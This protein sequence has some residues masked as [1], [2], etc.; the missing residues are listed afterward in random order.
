[1]V[2]MSTSLS[3]LILTLKLEQAA[4]ERLDSLRWAHF[5]PER[6]VIPALLTLFRA[7]PGNQEPAIHEKLR[8]IC[9]AMPVLSLR[10]P[11]LR[12]LGRSVAVEVEAPELMALRKQLAITWSNWLSAQ[13]QQGYRPHITIQNKVTSE[14]ARQ[15][16]AELAAGWEPFLATGEKL[17]LWRYLGGPWALV[18]VYRFVPAWPGKTGI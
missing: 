7:L 15:L 13:D 2:L 3:L 12:L 6:N 8:L 4:F 10:F 16:Y 18:D 5:P 1:M 14:D 9:A 11:T 17:L